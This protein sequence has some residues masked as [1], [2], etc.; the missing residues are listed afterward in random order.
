MKNRNFILFFS[1]RKL[2]LLFI[3]MAIFSGLIVSSQNTG[4]NPTL[5][6]FTAQRA[7][8]AVILNWTIRAGNNCATV[9][10][11]HSTDSINFEPIYEYPG[12]CGANSTDEQYAFTD[13][14]PSNGKNYYRMDLGNFGNS[15]VIPLY[16]I[17]FGSDGFTIAT[18][19]N[20][21]SSIYFNNPGNTLFTMDVYS[22]ESKLCYHKE[23]INGDNISIPLLPGEGIMIFRLT[24]KDGTVYTGKYFNKN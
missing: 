7:G 16:M 11:M 10:V 15:A 24:G 4:G 13:E 17:L 9:Y 8:D 19:E 14:S 5:V 3:S 1:G 2:R 20:G 18:N 23:Q 6:N 12:I 22:A 21:L